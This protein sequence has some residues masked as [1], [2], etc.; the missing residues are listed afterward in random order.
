M[1]HY[2][3][4]TPEEYE[5]AELNGISPIILD[6]RVRELGWKKEKAMTVPV[7]KLTDRKRWRYVAEDNGISY[8]SFMSRIR[9]GWSEEDAATKPLESPQ[10]VKEHALR[11][12]KC[13][14]VYPSEFI[15]LAEMNGIAYHTFRVRVKQLGWDYERA[16]TQPVMSKS[17]IGK[18]G[19]WARKGCESCTA[20]G[21]GSRSRS[22]Y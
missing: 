8:Q 1:S 7:R 20:I 5:E 3:Y 21:H 4:I 12:S 10:E 15:A 14:Q 18:L 22:K 6:R 2:F 13:M 17:E 19:N 9:R 11:A 16:A